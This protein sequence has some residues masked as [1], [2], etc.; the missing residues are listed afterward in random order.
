MDLDLLFAATH[1]ALGPSP[2]DEW[3]Q[4]MTAYQFN[5]LGF[6]HDCGALRSSAGEKGGEKERLEMLEL[7]FR[8]EAN[9]R[10]DLQS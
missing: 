1:L 7:Y 8:W 2:R 5:A 6:W 10:K 9:E 3:S 4:E